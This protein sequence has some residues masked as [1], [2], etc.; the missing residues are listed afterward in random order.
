MRKLKLDSLNVAS[1]ET[2]SD[3]PR[4]AGTV[5]AHAAAAPTYNPCYTWELNCGP[6]DGLDCTYTCTKM[7]SCAVDFCW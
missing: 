1:F 6:T 7:N 2:S 5:R 3:A 4:P